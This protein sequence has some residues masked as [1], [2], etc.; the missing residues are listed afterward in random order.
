MKKNIAIY[1]HWPFC[2]SLCP[3]CDFNSYVNNNIDYNQW[4]ECY[5]KEINYFVDQIKGKI[6]S[7]IFFGGGTPSLMKP[8]MVD[9]IINSLAK[10]TT[11]SHDCEI[12]L[13]ANPTSYEI[14]KF[15]EF[16]A[17]GVNRVSIGAQSFNDK[18]LRILGR[19][20]SAK[21]SINAIKSAST[22]F[23]EYSFD[24]IYARPKQT[25]QEWQD[26]IKLAL[27]LAGNHISLY[28]LVIEKGT[29]FFL[30]FKNNKIILPSENQ[31]IVMYNWTNE[32]L[33]QHNFYRYEISNYAKSNKKCIHNLSYWNYNEYLGIGPGAYSRI[34]NFNKVYSIVMLHKPNKWIS[35]VI[36]N[37]HGVQNRVQ[38]TVTEIVEEI[39][40]MGTRLV[41][42]I[43]ETKL[44]SLTGLVLKDVLKLEIIDLYIKKGLVK[45]KDNYFILTP[46]G[47]L[48]H[49]YLIP[50]ILL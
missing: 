29:I 15:K 18:G 44:Y 8:F 7:S 16:R 48:M 20:H 27:S 34:H 33:L 9:R 45:I 3:Y 35:S 40:M 23:P 28:Q 41:N 11:I 25:F 14:K 32:F 12:T 38:L 24:L 6:I 17:I 49:N 39:I 21:E 2:L 42:G 1:I 46:K 30:L 13:E 50:R 5:L 47:L 10:V 26:E 19:T 36:E 37:G 31:S 4:L 22:I 43:S